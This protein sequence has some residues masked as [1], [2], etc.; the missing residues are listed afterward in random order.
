MESSPIYR[1]SSPI[2]RLMV[3]SLIVIQPAS[4]VDAD[5]RAARLRLR[6]DFA[7]LAPASGPPRSFRLGASQRVPRAQFFSTYRTLF[8]LGSEDVMVELGSGQPVG[9]FTPYKYVQYHRDVPVIGAEYSVTELQG[10]VVVGLGR[11]VGGL[12]L[13]VAPARSEDD[14]ESVSTRY[15][16]DHHGMSDDDVVDM[17]AL[18]T[19]ALVI[20]SPDPTRGA[21]SYRLA[22]RVIRDTWVP[23]GR[24]IIDVDAQTG[25]LIQLRT[26]D[27]D[28]W[29]NANVL[30]FSLFD[31]PVTMTAEQDTDTGQLRLHETGEFDI[32]T[33]DAQGTAEENVDGSTGVDVTSPGP[34]FADPTTAGAVTAHWAA[35]RAL[36]F[37]K[38]QYGRDGFDG[39]G[40]TLTNF[41]DVTF[42]KPNAKW[43]PAVDGVLYSPDY[44]ALDVVAHEVA[45]GVI[46][47]SAGWFLAPGLEYQGEPGALSE[48]FAD[49]FS[50]A[51]TIETNGDVNDYTFGEDLYPASFIRRLDDPN[52]PNHEFLESADTYEGTNWIYPSNPFDHGGVHLNCGVPNFAFYLLAHGGPT[53]TN[54]KGD[55]YDVKPIGLYP[56][57][58]IAY[59]NLA[60]LGS[61]STMLDAREGARQTAIEIYGEHSQEHVSVT[62][63]WYA[64]GVGAA[65][66]SGPPA[67]PAASAVDVEPWKTHFEWTPGLGDAS[68]QIQIAKAPD[69]VQKVVDTSVA[70]PSFDTD[71]EPDRTYHW[72]VRRATTDPLIEGWRPARTFK[73]AKKTAVPIGPNAEVPVHPWKLTF[74]WHATP[75]ATEY[76]IE[77]AKDNSFNDLVTE[78]KTV[79]DLT[80][81]LDVPVD[82]ELYWRIRPSV[83]I[84]DATIEG[85]ESN[86]V[87]FT[88]KMPQA[89]I[90]GPDNADPV[91]PWPVHFEWEEVRGAHHYTVELSRNEN[92]WGTD[93]M[94]K[95]LDVIAPETSVDLNMRPAYAIDNEI[96]FWRVRVF[97]PPLFETDNEGDEGDPDDGLFLNAGDSTLVHMITPVTSDQVN[98]CNPRVEVTW[99]AVPGAVEYYIDVRTLPDHQ[100]GH[101]ELVESTKVIPDDPKASPVRGEVV[102]SPRS[103]SYTGINVRAIGP[104]E[105]EGLGQENHGA[106]I[107]VIPKKPEILGPLGSDV[108]DGTVSLSFEPVWS[109]AGHLIEVWFGGTSC[110]VGGGGVG[111]QVEISNGPFPLDVPAD[112]PVAWRVKARS[113][114]DLLGPYLTSLYPWSECSAF[115]T[116]PEAPPPPVITFPLAGDELTSQPPWAFC[117]I[118]VPDATDYEATF[119]APDGQQI[120]NEFSADDPG[121][122]P[123]NGPNDLCSEL[124]PSNGVAVT[125]GPHVIQMRTK[126]DDLWSTTSSSVDYF[127][128]EPGCEPPD[129]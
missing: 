70:T 72:R 12:S 17:P 38:G 44:I 53:G 15:L 3:V 47:S 34:T 32:V 49:L 74:T 113:D 20:V 28:A 45:H 56:A 81:E 57:A 76:T 75:G 92:D 4:S 66:G 100:G 125:C 108:P 52:A 127:H 26:V 55:S 97:G 59:G 99:D 10:S 54:D 118:P 36:A 2:Y 21:Q 105:I 85:A 101:A 86:G 120:V 96:V 80:A 43:S 48:H 27:A 19:I 82:S 60:K 6:D 69:F 84:G 68:W 103:T 91:H 73:T 14:A 102:I 13:S 30:G 95:T 29:V 35:E 112:M 25:A 111:F 123:G 83:T 121:L 67:T 16:A 51:I 18:P 78:K 39:S 93:S 109:P 104:E 46:N 63:S 90:L 88:T 87:K 124:V 61:A 79:P 115:A 5:D 23:L 122:F 77:V 40:T 71:L 65:Y 89:V 106:A 42:A 110:D 8:E 128:G 33:L 114:N 64:V 58:R 9:P 94:I 126:R 62:D 22:W 98:C 117:W 129:Q 50:T 7:E 107:L 24:H 1:A 41:V 116:E 31:G 37:F 119:T 11:V